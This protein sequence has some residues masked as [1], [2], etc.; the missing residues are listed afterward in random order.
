MHLCTDASVLCH[1]RNLADI[2]DGSWIPAI[3]NFGSVIDHSHLE[4]IERGQQLDQPVASMVRV[5]HGR[6]LHCYD[7]SWHSDG[8]EFWKE[9][10][11]GVLLPRRWRGRS[12]GHH[13][14]DHADT[15]SN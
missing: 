4:G 2:R 1:L 15:V 11:R 6:E 7:F 13:P 9:P 12:I 8:I 3:E 5:V 14:F 10:A